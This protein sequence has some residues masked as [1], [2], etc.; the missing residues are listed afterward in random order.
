M[1]NLIRSRSCFLRSPHAGWLRRA[2]TVALLPQ[3][4]VTVACAQSPL[5]SAA[6]VNS[7]GNGGASGSSP[8][9]H[10]EIKPSD[11]PPAKL[12]DEPN[13]PP[14]V[15]PQPQSAKLDLPPGFEIN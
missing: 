12:G 13:N 1:C 8:M 2:L 4:V 3:L 9:T 5:N 11:L 14:R 15:V 7:S 6:T 10:H